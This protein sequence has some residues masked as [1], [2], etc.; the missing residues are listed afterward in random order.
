MMAACLQFQWVDKED[1]R[2]IKEKMMRNSFF[3]CV[4]L[5]CTS[6]ALAAQIQTSP[7]PRPTNPMG[8]APGSIQSGTTAVPPA[9]APTPQTPCGA[10]ISTS[11]SLTSVTFAAG[12][13]SPTTSSLASSS[14]SLSSS[15]LSGSSLSSGALGSPSTLDTSSLSS[16]L[17]S[18][19]TP[20]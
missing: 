18:T 13:I 1:N 14:S 8:Q 2:T 3:G 6:T 5:L 9:P 15:S 20:P 19:M 17:S 4:S 10:P 12:Q 16:P 7:A 11:S